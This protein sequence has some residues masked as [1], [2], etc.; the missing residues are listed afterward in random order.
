MTYDQAI[1][2]FGGT[3]TTLARALGITQGTVSQWKRQVP[4]A[5]QFQIEVLSGRALT[6]DPELIPEGLRSGQAPAADRDA[7]V[8]QG[9]R[10]AIRLR[11]RRRSFSPATPD[12]PTHSSLGW[13]RRAGTLVADAAR[14]LYDVLTWRR[15]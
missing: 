10:T 12:A 9:A 15:R 4:P 5:Y 14:A 8:T 11:A 2:Y 6:V 1:E 13:P 7:V 3:Q